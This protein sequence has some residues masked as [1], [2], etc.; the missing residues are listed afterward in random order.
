M[1]EKELKT[2][3]ERALG[4]DIFLRRLDVKMALQSDAVTSYALHK[5]NLSDDSVLGSDSLYNTYTHLG[6]PPTPICNPGL[7]SIEAALNPEPNDYWYFLTD[8]AGQAHFS[9][10]YAGHLE[11]K[12]EFLQ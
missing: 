5:N 7:D 12:A 8:S 10:T 9:K 6:F 4:A 1:L 3:E 2:P 11:N